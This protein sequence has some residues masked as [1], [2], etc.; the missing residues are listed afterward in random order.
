MR[1]Y[2]KS[3]LSSR[4]TLTPTAYSRKFPQKFVEKKESMAGARGC[5]NCGGCAWC[6]RVVVVSLSRASCT[7]AACT[8]V[9]PSYRPSPF[10]LFSC[11]VWCGADGDRVFFYTLH[12]YRPDNQNSLSKKKMH[13]RDDSPDSHVGRCQS[14]TRPQTALRLAHPLGKHL[15][16]IRFFRIA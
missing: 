12:T 11:R 15:S 13:R 5:F 9:S 16:K 7:D 1:R 10:L 14:D 8:Y 4:V 2:F 6:F 3:S